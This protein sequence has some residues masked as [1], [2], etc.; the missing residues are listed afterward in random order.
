MCDFLHQEDL[1][2][3]FARA[4]GSTGKN[5]VLPEA[6]RERPEFWRDYS[7]DCQKRRPTDYFRRLAQRSKLDQLVREQRLQIERH[8]CG[9]SAEFQPPAMCAE[10]VH[11]AHIWDRAV[12]PA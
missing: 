1:P 5:I 3:R 7:W 8:C 10:N 6:S 11:V 2:F 4:A 9:I 12:F